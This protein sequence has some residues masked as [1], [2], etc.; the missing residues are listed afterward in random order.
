M[1]KDIGKMYAHMTVFF[2]IVKENWNP[3]VQRIVQRAKKIW[4]ISTP[5]APGG[6]HASQATLSPHARIA[7]AGG[8]AGRHEA[9]G[10]M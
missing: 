4:R 1:L 6:E 8:W 3:S 5:S 10:L 7:A 9:N 2:H